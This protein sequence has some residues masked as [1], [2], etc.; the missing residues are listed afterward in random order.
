MAGTEYTNAAEAGKTARAN[1]SP[2]QIEL[3][4][5]E[6]FA[7]GTQY[8]GRK[9]WFDPSVPLWE[10]APC[11]V[12]PI[13][14]IAIESNRD[15]VLGEGRFPIVT[16]NPGEDDSEVEGGLDEEASQRVDRGIAE[17]QRRVRFKTVS[18]QALVHAQQAKSVAVIVGARNGRAF[19]ELV[20]SRWCEP[21]FDA[22][23]KVSRLEIRY[24]YLQPEKQ[25]DGTWKLKPLLYRR[26]IDAQTDTTFLPIE[27]RQDGSEP[28]ADAWKADP[29]KTVDHKLGFCPVH[30]YAHQRECST[31]A[32]FDGEAIH[33]TI[34]D[35]IQGLDFTISQ[36]HRAALFCGDP[37]IIE[38][39]VDPGTNPSGQTGKVGI[40]A[41]TGGGK[42]SSAN[43]A[44]GSYQAGGDQ[45]SARVK[46]PGVVWQYQDPNT[47]VTYLVLP[48]EALQALDNHQ[49]DLR[50]KL[51]E[52]LAVVLI[53]P[54]N[55]K[56]TSDMSGR[57]IEQ[58]RARQFD[59]CDIIR[60]DFAD[61][62]CVPVTLLLARVAL[63]LN[64][65]I[66]AV[67]ACAKD[68]QK[69]I[70]DDE[71]RPMLTCKWP[72]RYIKP[73]AKDE[74]DTVAA[75]AAARTAKIV[76]RR[77]AVEKVAPIFGIT[78]VDQ[79]VEQLE[80]EDD[81]GA[82]AL[83]AAM[84]GLGGDPDDAGGEGGDTDNAGGGAKAPGAGD[85]SNDGGSSAPAQGSPKKAGAVRPSSPTGSP[86]PASSPSGASD[87]AT[88]SQAG[89]STS[90]VT[91]SLYDQLAEDFPPESIAW[92]RAAKVEGPIEVPIDQI[93][94]SNRDDWAASDE[95][96]RV[97]FFADRIK[98]G[99]R[100]PV[101]LVNEP[102]NE[103]LIVI[104]GHHRTLAYEKLGQPVYAYVVHVS[105]VTGPWD[106]MHNS[107]RKGG[108]P[109]PSRAAA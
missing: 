42:I 20:R 88:I 70:E 43:P 31:V 15:L 30:W 91:Q 35:E 96:D 81:E 12:Y 75:T 46:S 1:L 3:E 39:G 29:E 65:R 21:T 95:P 40:P 60:D 77:A 5:L 71:A 32:D 89:S 7:K 100:K 107:Q 101:V 26:V 24:P 73:T 97:D 19:A 103:K 102:N 11:I 36:R 8:E 44:T 106:V 57:A 109:K 94:F 58:I 69:F 25:P 67:Q 86:R 37:Q 22:D 83:H 38:A 63:V 59:R 85:Q 61:N 16:S 108:A 53:D 10:R 98:D 4:N 80:Q 93:D 27:A 66:P 17:L 74:S 9:S 56:F 84:G 99:K 76:P 48:P 45:Q 18:R 51:A 2:R 72:G 87:P 33:E 105:A 6:R 82:A 28:L 78:N 55:A 90:G 34:L 52:T 68:L 104:D 92:I 50:N 14:Q 41:S 49:A 23:G 79:A 64:L 62:W 47:K 13:V 54:Q